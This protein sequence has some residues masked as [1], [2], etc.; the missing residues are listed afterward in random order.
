MYYPKYALRGLATCLDRP[1]E[2]HIERIETLGC[3][4]IYTYEKERCVLQT[5]HLG[6][7]N[8]LG[9]LHE[10]TLEGRIGGKVKLREIDCRVH[11]TSFFQFFF[12]CKVSCSH[13]VV[14]QLH[15]GLL[16]STSLSNTVELLCE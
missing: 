16:F 4:Q 10:Q 14:S 15:F 3:M 5:D 2:A 12:Y 6:N 8:L 13:T 1:S 7:Y 9:C 11:L